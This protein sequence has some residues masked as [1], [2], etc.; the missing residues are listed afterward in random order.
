MRLL[1]QTVLFVTILTLA[2]CA[3]KPIKPAADSS[4]AVELSSVQAA[5]IIERMFME[6]STK[7][8]P[9]NVVVS[10]SF[11][12]LSTGT[13]TKSRGSAVGVPIGNAVVGIGSNKSETQAINERTYFERL[14]EPAL[15]TKRDWF[16]VQLRDVDNR[17][18]K[19][20]YTHYENL[21]NDFIRALNHF[22]RKSDNG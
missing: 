3:A 18:L 1:S 7:C 8:R 14:G 16:I 17:S 15:Y 13:V 11:I 12:G 21:A 6:Q 20:V 5:E 4:S 2:A 22:S 19:N 9:E 10:Q